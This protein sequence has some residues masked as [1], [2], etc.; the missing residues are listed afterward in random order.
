YLV[1]RVLHSFPTRRSSDLDEGSG[2]DGDRLIVIRAGLAT[3]GGRDGQ[4]GLVFP[5]T[6]PGLT[7]PALQ[8]DGANGRTVLVADDLAPRPGIDRKS[9]R[10]NSSHDQTSYA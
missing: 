2:T 6:G 1:H 3:A 10:L 9:T 8:G 4:V 7:R 5:L